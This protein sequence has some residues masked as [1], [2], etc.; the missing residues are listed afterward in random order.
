M[1]TLEKIVNVNEISLINIYG[2]NNDDVNFFVHL[3]KHLK[4]NDGNVYNRWCF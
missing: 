3:E 2:P 1:Q 4:E